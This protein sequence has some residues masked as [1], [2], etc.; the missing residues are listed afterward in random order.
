MNET[1]S[2]IFVAIVVFH[3]LYFAMFFEIFKIENTIAKINESSQIFD[4]DNSKF[5]QHDCCRC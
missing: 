4:R 5:S 3:D 2:M 1:T